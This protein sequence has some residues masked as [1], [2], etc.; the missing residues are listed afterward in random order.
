MR[1]NR[2]ANRFSCVVLALLS[3][4]SFVLGWDV[5]DT[6][7]PYTDAAF[8][9][10]EGTWMS[11]D[12]HP[13][14][15]LLVFDLL[16]DIYTLPTTGGL[17]TL[18]HGGSA[19]VR[20]P[21]FSPDG[22]LLLYVSDESGGDNA[23]V[24]RLDGSQARQVTRETKDVL[25]N[26]VWSPEGQYI[27]ATKLS[28]A[29]SDLFTSELRGYHLGGG[30][31][32]PIVESPSAFQN[33]TEAQFSPDG[34]YLY[35]THKVGGPEGTGVYIDANHTVHAV[36][37]RDLKTGKTKELLKGFGGATTAQ[38]SPDG[39]TIA[40]VRR[41]K[42]KTI[43]FVYDLETGEQR[44]VYDQLDRDLQGEWIAQGTYYPQYSWFPDGRF[45][46]IWGKG[47][48][49]KVDTHTASA[50]VIPFTVDAKH[51]ITQAT[52]FDASAAIQTDTVA[53]KAIRHL[54]VSPDQQTI[55]F[56]ALG[57]LWHKSLPNG[58][59]ERL[60]KSRAF[61]F[62]PAYSSDGK[63]IAYVEWDDEKGSVIRVMSA[64]GGNARA[65]IKSRGVIREPVFSHDGQTL[66]YRVQDDSKCMGG[67]GNDSG[68]FLLDIRTKTSP[69]LVAKSGV[70]LQFSPDDR[71]LF[72]QHSSYQNGAVVTELQSVNL[73]GY[74]KR[75]HAVL[76]GA[77]RTELSVS[78]NLKWIGFK[79]QQSYYAMPLNDA[80][81]AMNVSANAPATPLVRLSDEG[82]YNLAWASDSERLYWLLGDTL[83][84]FS[85][86][87]LAYSA[88]V[89][90]DLTVERDVP[91]GMLAFTGA[92]I[93]T[94]SDSDV[95][96]NGTVLVDGN[97][98]A[99]VGPVDQVE[100]PKSAKVIPSHGKTIMPGLINM[101]GHVESCYYEST[102]G[103]PQKQAALYA[104]LAFGVTTNFDP[105]SSELS[106]Y[107][108]GEMQRA[109]VIVSPRT[110]SVGSVIYG[111]PG[112][113]DSVYTP[114]S[115]LADAEKV[116]TR[117]RALGGTTIKS[118]RQPLRSQRQQL[119]KAARA[120]GIMVSIEGES[121]FYN[122][123]SSILDGHNTIEHNLPVANYYDDVVQLFAHSETASTP[124]LVALFG[125][126]LG[127][128]YIYQTSRTW[129]DPR[130]DS[131]VPEV[132]SG[133]SPLGI[134]YAAPLY[135]RGMTSLHADDERWEIGFRSVARSTKKLDDAGV[136][137]NVGSHSQVQG[138]AMHWEM[139]LMSEG[140]MSNERVLRAATVNGA[141]TL[142]LNKV[143]G[144]LEAG[145]LADLIVLDKNPLDNILNTKSVRQTMIGGRLYD[146]GSMDEIGNY[147]R[148]RSKFY[149]EQPDHTHSG[150]NRAASGQ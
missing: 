95:I 55:V 8:R 50:N 90:I 132:T 98:I 62:E 111:R 118:Y 103:I 108:S 58:K 91:K 36:M 29:Y 148:P 27:A 48:L 47:K 87:D 88:P 34:R 9:L 106:S 57:R 150:W 99:A 51:R 109:G 54:A 113:V 102:G 138:M 65:V 63:Q 86:D 149:W 89:S 20:M 19:M 37:Q 96:E 46:A 72:L 74:E 10:E 12:V 52:R 25:T 15:D 41:V 145:K 140:G 45:I 38:V 2:I 92:R 142:G 80:G 120:A 110:V 123:I 143:L 5:S 135:A 117:K 30:A 64:A 83:N 82:G 112:K 56:N 14:G 75:T 130:I 141:T 49:Y 105:Y 68:V 32:W 70:K 107:S 66:A 146:S 115:N 147:D 4:P 42:A 79:Q 67:F 116:M 7:Q 73:R 61:E 43:L 121:H 114:I 129:E 137:V 119:V 139:Q 97:R 3:W 84:S 69:V 133:Y 93:I 101:H 125:E 22:N 126:I 16:G 1:I 40:F 6:G 136:L 127:E 59:P 100:I 144:S 104:S 128:N 11:V 33:I 18:V 85:V 24:S 60:T 28:S 23:W 78:P 39:K 76:S 26:V 124:T 81:G 31:G 53:V 13:D 35:Y 44:P 134:Q 17:A 21:R 122:N 131:F 77:D 71:R 94:M